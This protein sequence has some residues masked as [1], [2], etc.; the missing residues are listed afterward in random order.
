MDK[1]ILSTLR[2]FQQEH[3][4]KHWESLS[5]TQQN[6][7]ESQINIIDFS[8]LNNLYNQAK[9]DKHTIEGEKSIKPLEY[10]SRD[11]YSKEELSRWRDLGLQAL[12][13]KK[14]AALLVAGG[15]GSRL[16][17]DG[18]K[19][20]FRLDLP[21]NK[22]LFQLQAERL[23]NLK[24]NLS[25]NIPWFIMTSNLNHQQTTEHFKENNYF[26]IDPQ[27]I[28]FFQQGMI[29][30]I[31]TNGKI[32]MSGPGEIALVPDGNGGC[33]SA[34]NRYGHIQWMQ[35]NDIEYLFVYGVDNALIKVC[36]PTY[37]GYSIDQDKKAS[38]K[39]VPKDYAEEKVGI[40][41]EV[42]GEPS[43]IEYSDMSEDMIHQKR[44]DGSLTYN[45]GNI[46][47]HLFSIDAIADLCKSPLPYHKAFK[48]IPFLDGNGE[49][50]HPEEPNAYKFEQ[51]MFDIFPR[52][53]ELS[54]FDVI[55]EEEFA[56]IKNAEGKD[57]PASARELLLNQ[58]KKWLETAGLNPGKKNYEISPLLSYEG[59]NLT[60]D[61]FNEAIHKDILPI[62]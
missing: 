33:F 4:L 26:G 6:S 10:D 42:N 8:L 11:K 59:E 40:F 62:P 57:S 58:Y 18:P 49:M 38:T 37:I 14:V 50:I 55:R 27:D 30:A 31:D 5:E 15:Q 46:A 32:L 35:E 17:F 2:E 43:V 28:F 3:L 16:G 61:T 34:L 7:L 45:A 22:S 56:P 47:V 1:K 36:D 13:E 48:K 52:I 25:T 39:V 41:V 54:C 21:G 29:P 20:M 19:G 12:K 23:K 53:G 9:F 60:E 51:F 24:E 44:S